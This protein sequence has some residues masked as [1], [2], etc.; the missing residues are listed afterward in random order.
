MRTVTYL[1]LRTRRARHRGG[2]QSPHLWLWGLIWRL[3][4]PKTLPWQTLE[5]QLPVLMHSQQWPP[6]T[7]PGLES[8]H[9]IA[10]ST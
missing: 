6:P 9:Q 1:V 4:L 8:H 10:L 2:L 5:L 3:L 7:L